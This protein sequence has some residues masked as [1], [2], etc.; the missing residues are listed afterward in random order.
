MKY[1]QHQKYPEAATDRVLSTLMTL[2]PS[3]PEAVKTELV[4]VGGLAVYLHTRGKANPLGPVCVTLDVDLGIALG[5]SNGCYETLGQTLHGLGFEPT[6]GRLTRQIEGL[7]IAIDFLV[8]GTN[9][10]GRSVDDIEASSFPG[11]LRA[12][13]SRT[14]I[15]I[16]GQNAYGV[17]LEMDIPTAAIG[18]LLVLKLNAFFHRRQ[19]KDAYDLMTLS[20]LHPKTSPRE[21]AEEESR[22]N[23]G[24]ALAR[25]CLEKFF[26]SA[27]NEGPRHALAFSIGDR[28]RRP[29]DSERETLEKIAT[30]GQI[31]LD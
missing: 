4:L 23:T 13:E 22:G 6:M 30:M 11:I 18:P 5:A 19:P 31:L 1:D 17:S 27:D 9:G 15:T 25:E 7:P 16:Q 2:W 21:F 29:S 8:E 3:I 10:G 26:Q 20:L 12:L 24:F 14:P 28:V